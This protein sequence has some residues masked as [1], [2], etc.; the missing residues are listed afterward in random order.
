M[1][2]GKQAGTNRY[3]LNGHSA[4]S[5]VSSWEIDPELMLDAVRAVL[6][7]GDAVLF[8]VTSDGGAVRVQVFSGGDKDSAYCSSVADLTDTL[9]ALRDNALA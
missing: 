9:S 7:N 5:Q 8:G 1:P 2:R 4:G 6:A 3:R